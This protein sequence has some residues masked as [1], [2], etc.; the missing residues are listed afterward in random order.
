GCSQATTAKAQSA[1]RMPDTVAIAATARALSADSMRG[2]GPWSREAERAARYLASRLDRLGAKPVFGDQ[3]LVPFT[4]PERPRDTV[5]NVI[6][7]LP[8]LGGGT[9]GDVVAMT[10]HLDHL[11]VDQPDARGDSIYNGF[12]DAA[13]P[14]AMVLDVASRYVKSPGNRPLVVMFFNLE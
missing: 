11:G 7:L 2:R 8:A 13:V 10:A 1:P 3:L 5:Y 12:L 6:G 9:T 4:T 14:M